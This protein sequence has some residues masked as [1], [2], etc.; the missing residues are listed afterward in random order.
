[1]DKGIK[2]II[3]T[4]G[5]GGVGYFLY[6]KGYFTSASAAKTT[7]APSVVKPTVKNPPVCDA[8][9]KLAMVNI[10]CQG[11]DCEV[12]CIPIP[13]VTEEKLNPTPVVTKPEPFVAVPENPVI[14]YPYTDI[15]V[16][17]IVNPYVGVPQNP[18]KPVT[19]NT[20]KADPIYVEQDPFENTARSKGSV[21]Y[22]INQMINR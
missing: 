7:T 4:L 13:A 21:D 9:Y 11:Q 3:A 14:F 16:P 6:K 18:D 1:M 15:P 8:G 22:E 10:K 17:L 2:L 19:D 12:H 5:L 20:F